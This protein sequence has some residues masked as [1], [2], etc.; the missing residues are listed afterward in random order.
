MRRF[1][2]RQ[3]KTLLAVGGVCALVV[4][5]WPLGLLRPGGSVPTLD[6]TPEDAPDAVSARL[7][8]RSIAK[9]AVAQEVVA[10]RLTLPEAAAVFGWLNRL[11]PSAMTDTLR[12]LHDTPRDAA[13]TDLDVLCYQVVL[14]VGQVAGRESPAYRAGRSAV[15]AGRCRPVCGRAEL[16]E[17]N[18][19]DCRHLLARAEEWV[20]GGA[21]SGAPDPLPRADDLR[22]VER[23]DE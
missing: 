17:V 8:A 11:S 18:D 12:G 4:A 20:A 1:K 5:V 9:S 14:Y 15:I 16:P 19:A 7:Q 10:G 13:L 2:M 23:P 3:F 21:A 6:P 22:L